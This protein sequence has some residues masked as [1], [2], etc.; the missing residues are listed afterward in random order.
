MEEVVGVCVLELDI[1]VFLVSLV[2]LVGFDMFWCVLTGFDS[3]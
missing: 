2:G 3:F 1:L